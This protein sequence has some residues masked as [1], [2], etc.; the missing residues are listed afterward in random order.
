MQKWGTELSLR[1]DEFVM[2]IDSF[3]LAEEEI[4]NLANS[5]KLWNF[6]EESRKVGLGK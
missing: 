6:R 2:A 5:M 3:R 4:V 1:K